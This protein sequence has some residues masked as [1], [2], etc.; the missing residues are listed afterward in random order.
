MQLPLLPPLDI[1]QILY[2]KI[3]KRQQYDYKF[4][5]YG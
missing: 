4:G 3:A 5:M 1:N 2:C